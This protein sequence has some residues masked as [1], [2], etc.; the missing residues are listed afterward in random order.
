[1]THPLI[2]LIMSIL[3][4]GTGV[5]YLRGKVRPGKCEPKVL[6]TILFA[7]AFILLSGS[8]VSY[9]IYPVIPHG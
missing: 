5:A 6:A 8:A 7:I 9:F 3:V 4:F 2:L 1:M